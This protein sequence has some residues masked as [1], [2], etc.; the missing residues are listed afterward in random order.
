MPR[1]QTRRVEIV[2]ESWIMPSE[3][4]TLPNKRV[5]LVLCAG[6]LHLG[7]ESQHLVE[8]WVLDFVNGAHNTGYFK[9]EVFLGFKTICN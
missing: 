1:V 4:H 3:F 5:N 7:I 8:M 2:F 9:I 6:G